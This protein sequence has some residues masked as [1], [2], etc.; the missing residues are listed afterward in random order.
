M[1]DNTMEGYYRLQ[2]DIYDI[3]RPFFLF[4]RTKVFNELNLKSG[5]TILE[6]G[7][8][9]GCN[10]SHLVRKAGTSGKIYGLDCSDSMLRKAKEKIDKYGWKNVTLI[11]EYAEK[12]NLSEKADMIIFSYSLT[13]IPDWKAAIDNAID[14]LKEDGKIVILDFYVWNKMK[15]FFDFWKSWL[16][17]NHVNISDEHVNYLKEKAWEFKLTIFRNG[18]NYMIEASF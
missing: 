9:T 17:V 11:K 14:N 12:Y 7:C 1:P 10:L 4:D 15:G 2:A 16:K 6:V 3:T 18:Y 13:M 5:Q 8:G